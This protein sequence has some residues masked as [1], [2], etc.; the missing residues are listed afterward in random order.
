MDA[1]RLADLVPPAISYHVLKKKAI[2]YPAE[3]FPN[4]FFVCVCCF[5]QVRKEE[6]WRKRRA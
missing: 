2:S 4:L 3:L 6:G 5:K 1:S